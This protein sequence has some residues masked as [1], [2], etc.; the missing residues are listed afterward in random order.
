MILEITEAEGK[1]IGDAARHGNQLAIR[2]VQ[3]YSF[4]HKVPGD[5]CAKMLFLEAL[6]EWR[7]KQEQTKN[8]QYQI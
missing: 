4:W 7:N 2:V 5:M 8:G 3:S 1:I 6:N